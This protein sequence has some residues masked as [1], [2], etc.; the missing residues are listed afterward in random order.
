MITRVLFTLW[1]CFLSADANALFLAKRKTEHNGG[2]T[3]INPTSAASFNRGYPFINFI[4]TAS[5]PVYHNGDALVDPSDLDEN[6]YPL[7]IVNGGIKLNM[8]AFPPQSVYSGNYVLKFKGTGTVTLV[9]STGLV[10]GKATGCTIV[11]VTCAGTDGRVTFTSTIPNNQFVA[12]ITVTDPANR[13]YELALVREDEEA[14]Y[15]AGQIFSPAFLRALK[16]ANFGTIRFMDLIDTNPSM[17]ARWEDRKPLGYITWAG[18]QLKGSIYAGSVSAG[19]GSN[20]TSAYPLTV[21]PADKTLSLIH[22]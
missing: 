18:V 6:G 13:I 16:G 21:N 17:V 20:Y 9:N 7:T 1:F 4:K 5:A 11:G 14:L 12:G 22:I 19:G 8:V 15:D 10:M 3:Q 2:V